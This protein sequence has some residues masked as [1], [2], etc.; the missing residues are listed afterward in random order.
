MEANRRMQIHHSQAAPHCATPGPFGLIYRP[1]DQSVPAAPEPTDAEFD[2][3]DWAGVS[4]YGYAFARRCGS[5]HAE[6][7]GAYSVGVDLFDYGQAIRGGATHIQA[8]AAQI[9]L[10]LVGQ[11]DDAH[12][13]VFT[14]IMADSLALAS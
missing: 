12:R 2:E 5:S 7:M 13:Q 1:A 4:I 11:S 3:A 6:T 9:G 8:L 14:R 10:V